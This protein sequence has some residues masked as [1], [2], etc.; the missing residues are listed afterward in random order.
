MKKHLPFLLFT[1]LSL[2]IVACNSSV[3]DEELNEPNVPE[4]EDYRLGFSRQVIQKYTKDNNFAGL[5]SEQRDFE[6]EKQEDYDVEYEKVRATGSY[7]DLCTMGVNDDILYPGAIVDMM[8]DSYRPIYIDRAPITLSTNL[9]TTPN[10]TAKIYS[11]VEN[12]NLSSVRQGIREIVRENVP[13]STEGLPSNITL[14]IK[15]TESVDEFYLNLGLGIQVKKLNISE[16]FSYDKI[17]KQT[18]LTIVL[19][20]IY[21]TV[22]VDY[23]GIRGFFSDKLSNAEI[24]KTLKGTIPAYVSSVSY[25]RI[26]FIS[27]QSNY[28]QAEITNALNVAWGKMS[29]NP[30][31][32]SL[33][34]LSVEFDSTLK[35]ISKDSD[36]SI[37]YFVYGGGS[38]LGTQVSTLTSNSA[39]V[40]SN[41]F[42]SFDATAAVGMPISYKLR[43]L[44]GEVAKIQ[45]AS[46]YVVKRVTYN[47][48]KIMNWSY[49]DAIYSDG[50]IFNKDILK[51]DFSAMVNYEDLSKT[52]TQANKVIII[53]S[54]ITELHLI[55]PNDSAHKIVYENLSFIFAYRGIDK[56]IRILLK[57]ISLSG[58]KEADGICFSRAR[59]SLGSSSD[60]MEMNIEIDGL[61]ELIS[62]SNSPVI[63]GHDINITGS[64][65]FILRGYENEKLEG[66]AS[67]ST[68]QASGDVNIDIQGSI[69]VLGLKSF[70][71]PVSGKGLDGGNAIA[72]ETISIKTGALSKFVG[73]IGGDGKDGTGQDGG[74]G[75]AIF[76]SEELTIYPGKYIFEFGSGGNGGAGFSY[77]RTENEFGYASDGRNGQNGG[78]GG[79]SSTLLNKQ[80]VIT[81]SE[82]RHTYSIVFGNGGNG[83]TGGDGEFAG[84]DK[85]PTANAGNGGNGGNG[86][87]SLPADLSKLVNYKNYIKIDSVKLGNGGDAGNGGNGGHSDESWVVFVKAKWSNPGEGGLPGSIGRSIS[88]FDYSDFKEFTVIEGSNGKAGSSGEK[89]KNDYY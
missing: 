86:G 63:E 30:G 23:T 46:E 33:K 57:N 13:S 47:P 38:D 21:Y 2:S 37:K 40:I 62:N 20:Q 25:G 3:P 76:N 88:T 35:C 50:S 85:N 80:E 65:E 36:T 77:S 60:M 14:E 48:K 24:N 72:A 16:N 28:S 15:E 27:I 4:Y 17:S 56:P 69:N 49:L 32:S 51:L 59:S 8:N 78:N 22:D 89:G 81:I 70:T 45:D 26:A 74:A 9:E 7:D 10:Q 66:V 71:N 1:A 12:P 73:G 44:N 83:A 43:H 18:N 19:K 29:D 82:G 54:N 58:N 87:D 6:L 41:I 53:P 61:V 34:K 11:T 39:D 64:G 75:G 79:N 67:N 5:P 52:D 55:G 68:I 31:S 84:F 42:Q